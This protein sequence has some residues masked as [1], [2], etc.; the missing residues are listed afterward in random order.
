MEAKN[1]LTPAELRDAFGEP[2]S[3]EIEGHP[4][5]TIIIDA[6]KVARREAMTALLDDAEKRGAI[7]L[8]A[9]EQRAFD[10][11][12][13]ALD[14][15][16]V[17]EAE[18]A[19]GGRAQRSADALRRIGGA[20]RVT[21][22]N[23]TYEAHGEHSYFGDL[24]AFRTF[25]DGSALTRLQRH[26]Q[27]T[28]NRIARDEYV[29][30]KH[31]QEQ[32]DLSRTDGSGGYFVPPAWLMEDAV[33]LARAGRPTANVVRNLPLP[34]GTDSLN[35][36]K[37]S[38]GTTTAIQTTDNQSV[39]ETDLADTSVSA[40]VKTIAGQQDVAIQALEQS[41]IAFDQIIFAD[42][43][44]AYNTNVDTQVISGANS[45]GEVKGILSMSGNNSTTY[46]DTTPSV[47][48]LWPKIADAINKVHVNRYLSPNVIV[49]HPTRW[50]W[51]LATLD[52]SGRPLVVA[53]DAQGATNAIATVS[54]VTS[55]GVVGTLQGLPVVVDPS[56]PTNLGSGTNE[57]RIIVMRANDVYLWESAV[58][59]RVLPEVGSGTLTVRLQAYG[60]LAFTAERIPKA[61]SI[62]SGSGLST[63]SF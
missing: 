55:E 28:E 25:G 18:I 43:L 27:E 23:G 22:E 2:G 10:A 51:F 16:A 48:E 29:D 36:P 33:A 24:V 37:I 26:A 57:D 61:V 53:N 6:Q 30:A 32:R 12:K 47:S 62:I 52:S 41:P 31:S 40:G 14:L 59:T 8:R 58:R 63:P 44:G 15:L 7:E 34:A 46:T 11:H 56:I 38:T 21:R 42:L 4:R 1:L 35:L 5:P 20:A 9:S 45:A 49:M 17:Y 54:Q 50:A 13:A 3:G 39:S 19:D 60:Y